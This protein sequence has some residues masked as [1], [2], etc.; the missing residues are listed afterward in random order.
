[1]LQVIQTGSL[2]LSRQPFPS[3]EA[4]LDGEREPG[5]N[6]GI[7]KAENG[8]DLVVVEEQAFARA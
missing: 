8:M 5:L 3:V 4:N 1:M 6:A 2:H 7:E